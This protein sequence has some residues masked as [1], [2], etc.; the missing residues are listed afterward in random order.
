MVIL[1]LNVLLTQGL[2]WYMNS[3]SNVH[4]DDVDMTLWLRLI[5]VLILPFL[6][7]ISLFF[8]RVCIG[9]ALR[10]F[11]LDLIY[12]S[13]WSLDKFVKLFIATFSSLMC[14]HVLWIWIPL[15][16]NCIISLKCQLHYLLLGI[17][18]KSYGWFWVLIRLCLSDI[19]AATFGCMFGIFIYGYVEWKL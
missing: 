13:H 18:C 11:V 10:I 12:F 17:N 16:V 14:N 6:K 15:N 2:R 5:L 4:I 1:K 3:F 9:I 8:C 7:I 19:L